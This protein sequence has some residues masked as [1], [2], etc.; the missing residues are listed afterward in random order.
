MLRPSRGKQEQ[1][2]TERDFNILL[3]LDI[4]EVEQHKHHP[5]EDCQSSVPVVTSF[6]TELRN[7][8]SIVYKKNCSIQNMT[9]YNTYEEERC[10]NHYPCK[11][12][13]TANGNYKTKC[14]GRDGGQLENC[15]QS[16]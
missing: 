13:E 9:V 7:S 10:S 12:I 8:C 2:F 6:D 11:G 15:S 16:L 5:Q 3:L 4:S 14:Q 1:F